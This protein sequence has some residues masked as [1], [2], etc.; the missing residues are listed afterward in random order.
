VVS[1]VQLVRQATGGPAE[2][3]NP[4]Q[5][6]VE[7]ATQ[8]PAPLQTFCWTIDEF[9]PSQAGVAL[10]TVLAPYLRHAPEPFQLPV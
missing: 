2:Q 4:L 1:S 3:R 7:L 10:Q 9:V 6:W 5:L 8:E